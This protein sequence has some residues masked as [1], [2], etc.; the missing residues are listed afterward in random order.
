MILHVG[1]E[2]VVLVED[3]IAII[4]VDT[5]M[6]S[7]ETRKYLQS[8]KENGEMIYIGDETPKSYIVTVSRSA[9]DLTKKGRKDTPRGTMNRPQ[10][11]RI[12]ISPISSSTLLKRSGYVGALSM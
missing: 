12:Y 3:I 2:T 4:D 8:A 9:V 1:G 11:H 5:A 7:K 6:S 10:K